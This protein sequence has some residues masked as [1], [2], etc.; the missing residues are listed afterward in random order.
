LRVS[1]GGRGSKILT[2]GAPGRGVDR[3]ST[4]ELDG[5]LQLHQAVLDEGI[6]FIFGFWI[7]VANSLGSFNSHL[8]DCRKPEASAPTRH[9]DLDEFIDNLDELPLHDLVLQIEK[10]SIFDVTQTNMR[11]HTIQVPL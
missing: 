2:A 3:A 1:L 5:I 7:C 11:D 8:I 4:G 9:N 10:M 6:T